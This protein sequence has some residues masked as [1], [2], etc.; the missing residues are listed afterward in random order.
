VN[1]NR[2]LGA[3]TE[4]AETGVMEERVVDR[5]GLLDGE[6]APEDWSMGMK[7]AEPPMYCVGKVC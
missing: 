5:F 6:R 7:R 3:T 4:E 2:W 1:L